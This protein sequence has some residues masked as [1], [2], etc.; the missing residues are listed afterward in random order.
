MKT[1]KFSVEVD[2]KLVDQVRSR[3]DRLSLQAVSMCSIV[4]Q[5]LRAAIP[6]LDNLLTEKQRQ[7]GAVVLKKYEKYIRNNQPQEV[8]A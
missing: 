5:G 2:A 7:E 1:K 6:M 8:T 3:L 4:E